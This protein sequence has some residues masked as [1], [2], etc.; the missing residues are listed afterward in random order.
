[1]TNEKNFFFKQKDKTSTIEDKMKI[2]CYKRMDGEKND[3]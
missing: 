1:M 2:K 3:D